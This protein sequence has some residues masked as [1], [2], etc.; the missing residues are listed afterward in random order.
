MQS[1]INPTGSPE[2][3]KCD[4]GQEELLCEKKPRADPESRGSVRDSSGS[5]PL[6]YDINMSRDEQ[7]DTDCV[8]TTTFSDCACASPC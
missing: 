8:I 1:E 3:A 4:S 5:L 6:I 7:Y 2:E